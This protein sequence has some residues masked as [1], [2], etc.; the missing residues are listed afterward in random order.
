[1]IP[2]IDICTCE[3]LQAGKLCPACTLEQESQKRWQPILE[4]FE[5]EHPE[6]IADPS[7]ILPA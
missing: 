5:Q 6:R 7:R 1:M 4:R 2:A 3:Q